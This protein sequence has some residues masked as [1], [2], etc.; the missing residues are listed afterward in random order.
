MNDE[1][2]MNL[3]GGQL[4]E[5]EVKPDIEPVPE[6]EGENKRKVIQIETDTIQLPT[7]EIADKR[8]NIDIS[9]E[10]IQEISLIASGG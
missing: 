10:Y 7:C 6:P 3:L 2:I 8:Y 5:V 4:K 1:D 9:N